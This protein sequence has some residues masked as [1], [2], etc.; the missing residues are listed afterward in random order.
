MKHILSLVLTVAVISAGNLSMAQKRSKLHEPAGRGDLA[1]VKEI[2]KNGGKV[3]KKDIAGQTP[4]MYAAEA[5]GLEMVKYLVEMGADVDAASG[6][7]G[8]GTPLIYA[9]STN[10]IEV[11][12]YLLENNADINATT[13][14]QNETALIWAVAAGSTTVVRILVERGADQKITNKKGDNVI[15]IA[16]SLNRK[17]I[18]EL[19][20]GN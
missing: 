15:D 5:G 9:A 11:V 18:L 1:T 13:K 14:S 16:K 7:K 17:D 8:R 4:L 6:I 10:Q 3:D 12:K 20:T 19:L 2:I